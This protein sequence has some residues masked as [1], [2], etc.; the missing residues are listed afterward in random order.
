MVHTILSGNPVTNRLNEFK[1]I[2]LSQHYA[3]QRLNNNK[4]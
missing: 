2:T 3:L 4:Q 1:V